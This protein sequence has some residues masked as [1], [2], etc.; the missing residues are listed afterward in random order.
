MPAPYY[1]R[2]RFLPL[3]ATYLLSSLWGIQACLLVHTLTQFNHSPVEQRKDRRR[4]VFFSGLVFLLST[5]SW[6]FFLR[7]PSIPLMDPFASY[8]DMYNERESILDSASRIGCNH[9]AS[10]VGVAFLISRATIT[11]NHTHYSRWI[12]SAA[13]MLYLGVCIAS[14]FFQVDALRRLSRAASDLWDQNGSVSIWDA[15]EVT[16]PLQKSFK[17]WRKA[18]FMGSV[19]V[20]V[21]SAL[22]IAGPR[23]WSLWRLREPHGYRMVISLESGVVLGGVVIGAIGVFL[24]SR[25]RDENPI[26]FPGGF[27]P[28]PDVTYLMHAIWISTLA[29]SS[30]SILFQLVSRTTLSSD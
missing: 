12:P 7:E 10:L 25:E 29:I 2:E 19:A 24:K 6:V 21:I 28:T 20:S 15:V 11:W 17:W 8:Q 22:M 14:T 23:L 13:Y 1:Y 16:D 9:A 4:F 5:T 26:P 18:E 3:Y 30:Q 27:E